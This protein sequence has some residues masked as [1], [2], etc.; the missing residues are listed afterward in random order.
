MLKNDCVSSDHVK[1]LHMQYIHV[2]VPDTLKKQDKKNASRHTEERGN[3]HLNTGVTKHMFR[4]PLL[5]ESH[6]QVFHP[7]GMQIVNKFRENRRKKELK[8]CELMLVSLP[9]CYVIISLHI[10]MVAFGWKYKK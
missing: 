6:K 2:A 7:N 5:E 1:C 10:V 9:Y 4:Q 8:N 3:N